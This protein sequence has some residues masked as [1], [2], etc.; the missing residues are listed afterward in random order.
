MKEIFLRER[1]GSFAENKDLA[2]RIREE[3][4]KPALANAEE[5][6]LDFDGVTLA[7]QSFIHAMIS[8]PIRLHGAS[9]LD[10]IS[11]RNCNEGIKTIVTVV[12]DYM[13]DS[14]GTD[15]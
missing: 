5:V 8:E 4:I 11:F 15:E 10:F 13:Q 7:T 3:D 6:V 9:V 14:F 2:K 12:C 1:V